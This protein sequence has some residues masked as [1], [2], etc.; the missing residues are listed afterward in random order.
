MMVRNKCEYC[1]N[2]DGS[3]PWECEKCIEKEI[4]KRTE[5]RLEEQKDRIREKIKKPV[6]K[7]KKPI[8]YTKSYISQWEP[9]DEP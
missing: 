9:D 7:K 2:N 3:S 1:D 5:D 6:I 4:N 8:D